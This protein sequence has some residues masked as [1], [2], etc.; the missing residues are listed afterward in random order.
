MGEATLAWELECQ[1][2]EGPAWF[3]DEQLLRFV[4]IKRGHIHSFDP[5]T[6]AKETFDV[7]GQPSF[8]VPEEGGAAIVGSN[9]GLHRFA[10]GQM[11]Q[12][13]I[14]I[15]DIEGNR[16]NDATVDRSGR[17]WFG[18]MDDRHSGKMGALW[19]IEDA[20]LRRTEVEAAITNGPALSPDGEWLYH[21]DTIKRLVWKYPASAKPKFGEGDVIIEIAHGDGLPDGVVVDSEGCIWLG[22]WNGWGVRRYDASGK[23]LTHID[24]PCANITKLAFGGP[25]L[26]TAYV[27]SA[28]SGLSPEQ[29]RDQPLAGSLFAFETSVAGLPLPK[30]RRIGPGGH[31]S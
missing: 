3:P 7:G 27:T 29:L 1:L 19:Y 15:P 13:V 21:V 8:I 25:G 28:R 23:L 9:L 2:G 14:A 11:G 17:L 10:S 22:L 20:A 6:G 12:P 5:A 16:T 4:D 30:A 31:S 24:M 26:T 18:T